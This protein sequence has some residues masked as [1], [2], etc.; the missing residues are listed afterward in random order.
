MNLPQIL[1]VAIVFAVGLGVGSL[2]AFVFRKRLRFK[3]HLIEIRNG[4]FGRETILLD[5]QVLASK[6]AFGGTYKFMI[7]QDHA[8][9]RM[10]YRWHLLGVRVCFQVDDQ[11]CYED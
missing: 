6:L 5:N 4:P 9:V 3:D 10:R 1:V 8:E 2:P 11:L 7:G